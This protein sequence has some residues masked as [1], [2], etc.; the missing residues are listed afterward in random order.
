[1]NKKSYLKS[2]FV[3]VIIAILISILVYAVSFSN[4]VP[5]DGAYD[6]DGSDI[7]FN[8]TVTP[9]SGQNITNISFWTDASTLWLA[10]SSLAEFSYT[11]DSL[12][13]TSRTVG[14]IFNTINNASIVD[15]TDLK[16]GVAVWEN[17][18][19][20]PTFSTNFT[21]NVEYPP[22]ITLNQPADSSWNNK[23]TADDKF[24]FTVTS[25]FA[26]SPLFDCRFYTN[27]TTTWAVQKSFVVNNNT[28]YAFR[29]QVPELTDVRW[30]ILCLES[31]D[32]NVF[33]SSVNR[34]IKIDRTEP[35][36]NLNSI[37]NQST[38][39]LIYTN[40]V[41]MLF[42]YTLTE[43]N[44]DT[45]KLY[46]NSTLNRTN[47]DPISFRNF[48]NVEI[49]DGFYV[50]R[51]GCN[52][53]A[54]NDVNSSNRS[55]IVDTDT[56][57][58]TAWGNASVSGTADDRLFN[59]TAD[60]E[61]NFTIYYGSTTEVTSVK[62]LSNFALNHNTTI[63]DFVQNTQYYW[64]ITICDRATNCNQS[65]IVN[66]QFDFTFPWRILGPGWSYFKVFDAVINFSTIL[67]E[68]ETEYVY[69]WNSSRQSWVSATSGGTTN[70]EFQVGH[71][72]GSVPGG[73]RHVIALYES[74]NST[75]QLRNTSADSS[76]SVSLYS[77]NISSGDN[78]IGLPTDY[79]FGNFTRSMF[80][81]SLEPG[82]ST[83]TTLGWGDVGC[84]TPEGLEYNVTD[85]WFAA[86]N[87]SALS[88]GS[89]YVY[90]F[91]LDNNTVL[92]QPSDFEVVWMFSLKNL[93]WN[94][95]NVIGNW[96]RKG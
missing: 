32:S 43:S 16:W 38:S 83:Q 8:L 92:T 65:G 11:G 74:V 75:W 64:N 96:T 56:P 7:S 55:F 87:R 58:L 60:E 84:A 71:A 59:I 28:D 41:P 95:T 49:S 54:A 50:A 5:V 69:F 81:G 61:V 37:N 15:G 21:V 93:T 30:G 68:T 1:M 22:A 23:T 10:N 36:I 47:A 57:S 17:G 70:M 85:L 40:D 44:L 2:M 29:Y 6:L 9:T 86:Y 27:E 24:N 53:S 82:G 34:T 77:L 39:S 18:S 3:L 31:S 42:N 79:T 76:K 51:I 48:T 63:S 14:F 25:G 4:R 26:N 91:T 66:G 90:N 20:N 33:N 80:N 12:T 45:C 88:W 94:G 19:T 89:G 13:D 52:D 78:F 67:N 73:G 46:I 72:V 35:S 62:A